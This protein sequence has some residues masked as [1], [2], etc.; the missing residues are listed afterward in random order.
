M[1]PL[2]N[3]R[4]VQLYIRPIEAGERGTRRERERAAVAQ[5]VAEVFG[6]DAVYAHR[7]DGSPYI[8]GSP[9]HISVSHCRGYAAVIVAQRDGIGVDIEELRGAQLQRV[10]DRYLGPVQTR[11]YTCDEERLWAWTAKEAIYKASGQRDL[12]GPEIWVG[13]PYG[14]EAAARGRIYTLSS[15]RTV[16]WCLV[17]ATKNAVCET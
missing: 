17:V 4:D 14:T 1:Y 6:P 9:L 11:L 15:L 3:H 5:I 8:V 16:D 13:K 2:I 12:E 10:A 7:A